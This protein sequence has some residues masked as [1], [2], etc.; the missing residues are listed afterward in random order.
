V[1]RVTGRDADR[2]SGSNANGEP[3]AA[4][5]ATSVEAAAQAAELVAAF[6]LARQAWP[7]VE[8]DFDSYRNHLEALGWTESLPPHPSE[9]YLCCASARADENACQLLD[10]SFLASLRGAV[11][12]IDSSD[13]FVAE[14]LQV[15]RTRLLSGEAPRIG[16][17]TG[18]GPLTAWLRVAATRVALDQQR[19]RRRRRERPESLGEQHEETQGAPEDFVFKQAYAR[20][21][22]A[23]LQRAL[24]SM[25]AQE[26]NV[27]RLHFVRGLNIEAIGRIYGVHRATVARWIARHRTQLLADVT[28]QI[29]EQLGHL[30]DSEIDSLV[31]LVRDDVDF[32]LSELLRSTQLPQGGDPAT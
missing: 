18:R 31:R 1:E 11:A 3:E 16:T 24:A 22:E 13:D 4:E 5:P 29:K 28:S 2:Q 23:A 32:S 25:S 21:F 27:L 30:R 20:I 8:V 6:E 10:R 15:L 9:L 26:R 19:T 14:A 17:Y 12:R 7:L